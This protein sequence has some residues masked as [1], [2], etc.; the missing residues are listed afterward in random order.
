MFCVSCSVVSNSL[1][2][3]ELSPARLLCPWDS[4]SSNTGVGCHFLL[5]KSALTIHF[6]KN[7]I[8]KKYNAYFNMTALYYRKICLNCQMIKFC[9]KKYNVI[10]CMHKFLKRMKIRSMKVNLALWSFRHKNLNCV[11][12]V[13]GTSWQKL[14]RQC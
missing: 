11:I 14:N 9:S 12:Q 13:R 1:R 8:L 4:P 3:H 6:Q 2:P 7:I 10:K 5:Q